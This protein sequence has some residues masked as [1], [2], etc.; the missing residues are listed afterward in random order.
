MTSPRTVDRH[1][2]TL[3]LAHL[4]LGGAERVMCTMANYWAQ[5]GW[6]VTLLTLNHGAMD[7]RH[8]L[9]SRVIWR[10]M[11]FAAT[12]RAAYPKLR[13]LACLRKLRR[14]VVESRP[15]AVISFLTS[16]NVMTLL[17][18]AGLRV[19]VIVSERVDPAHEP[20]SRR[21]E[22][23]RRLTYPRASRLVVQTS[24][25]RHYFSEGL[26]RRSIVIPNPV[27]FPART[28]PKGASNLVIGIG[29][30]AEQKRFDRLIRAFHAIA[31]QNP[32]WTLEIWGDGPE[33][34][35]LECLI[36]EL[37]VGQRVALR[38]Y[39]HDISA[40]LARARIFVLSSDFEGFPNALC[41]AMANGVASI[42]TDCPS[43]PSDIIQNGV[44]GVLVARESTDELATAIDG[45]M[46]DAPARDAIAA[47]GRKIVERFTLS[48]VMNQWESAI[49][50]ARAGN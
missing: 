48:G 26:R 11:D 38:G 29:R 45:L 10:D 18:T 33:R 25:A 32:S 30:L 27:D 50:D 14:A 2:V 46:G 36:G 3:A 35:A 43:G 31:G 21:W 40:Q 17:A 24:A 28:E 5:Q 39:T 23:L 44:N 4:G 41:E 13:T 34:P 9:D 8:Q 6:D 1:R 22:Q 37:G 42:S 7:V 12:R 16:T 20:I 19:P 49:D 15:D 47:Q